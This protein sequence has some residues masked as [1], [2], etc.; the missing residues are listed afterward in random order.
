MEK[1]TFGLIADAWAR[2]TENDGRGRGDVLHRM[3]QGMWMGEF[4]SG[5][6]SLLS[7]V[8]PGCALEPGVAVD[9]SGNISGLEDAGAITRRGLLRVLEL[10]GILPRLPPSVSQPPAASQSAGIDGEKTFAAL[11]AMPASQFGQLVSN[12]YLEALIVSRDDFGAWC[13]GQGFE[14]PAFWFSDKAGA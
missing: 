13:D 6:K 10:K 12:A 4:E 8:V 11:A 14:R 5:G 2:E 9:G 3:L 1:L 7:I